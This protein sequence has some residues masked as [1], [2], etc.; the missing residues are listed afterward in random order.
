M[1]KRATLC[2]EQ[3][4]NNARHNIENY[5]WAKKHAA[6]VI[7]AADKY[8]NKYT[9]TELWEL[10]PNQAVFRSYGVNQKLGCL[11]CG[12][13]IDAFGNY[14]YRGSAF[15]APWKVTCPS[16]G[17]TFPS[18]DFGAYYRSALD[19]NGLFDPARGD[20]SLLIN[21]MYPEKDADYGVDDGYG[22]ITPDG[23]KY[24][25]IAYYTHWM[26]WSSHLIDG[27]NLL[28]LAYAYTGEQKYADAGI[29]MLD[30]I[31]D[32][33]PDMSGKGHGHDIGF[34]QS[35]GSS[36]RSKILGCIWETGTA[37]K[38]ANSIDRL[39]GGLYSL[40]EEAKSVIFEK[41]HG[42]KSSCGDI[43]ANLEKGI[44]H[45][46]FDAVR[47]REIDG[48]NGMHQEALCA[49]AVVLDDE[50]LTKKWLDFVFE[51]YG[52]KD[53]L[54][55]G[56]NTSV[57]FVNDIDRD[58]FGG[59][60]SPGYNS[61]WLSCYLGAA[62]ILKNISHSP[63][64]KFEYNLYK[65]PKFK[66]MFYSFTRLIMSVNFTPQIGDT[67]ATG[68]P[69]VIVNKNALLR[70]Y[71]VYRD[72]YLARAVYT[73]NGNSVKGLNLG[74]FDEDAQELRAEIESIIKKDGPLEE[75]DVN[76]TGYGFTSLKFIN[77]DCDN[78]E[79]S[80]A[81]YYGSNVGHGH[82][83]TLNYYLYAYNI[84]I[85]PDLGYPEFCDNADMHRL[86]WVDNTIS[87]NTVIVDNR[88][89]FRNRVGK[90]EEFA[91]F[92]TVKLTSASAPAPYPI[93]EIY[94]RTS[95]LVKTGS[96]AYLVDFF[97]VKGGKKHMLSFHPAESESLTTSG[98]S[99]VP[100][101][102]DNGY[103]VGTM[104]GKDT[105]LGSVNDES[106]LQWLGEVQHDTAQHVPGDVASF[107][108]TITD[109]WKT[110]SKKDIHLKYTLV[111]ELGNLT[112]A[113]GIPP[114]N[115]VGNPK[116]LDYILSEREN[117]SGSLD[118]LFCS[119]VEPYSVK[120][121]ILNVR[122]LRA[123]R[124]GE[125]VLDNSAKAVKVSLSDGRSDVFIISYDR[126]C[127]INI[128]GLFDFKGFFACVRY[129]ADGSVVSVNAVD[130]DEVCGI[131][132]T[133]RFEGRVC[134]FT[135]ELCDKNHIDVVFTGELH[136]D[137]SGLAGKVVYVENDGALNGAY[138]ILSAE[139]ISNNT[140]RLDIG[141]VTLIRSYRN[142]NEGDLG[143]IY[144]ISEGADVHIP[145]TIR[146]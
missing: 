130:A 39:F 100:Q 26:L 34:K 123:F 74:I 117:E 43:L 95:S 107:D 42:K 106:G 109:T 29:V 82:P 48:N 32:I 46:I 93:T 83:D 5:E 139:P 31:A 25:F 11:N 146:V 115:K 8:L 124:N 21:T 3:S 9:L 127:L 27:V 63:S 64:D 22:Y 126:S 84:N 40:G 96:D 16:C 44:L 102:D 58:G 137:I 118:S 87:H 45:E 67:G 2:T 57:T 47:R 70:G 12:H 101:T 72:P 19:E 133:A 52:I 18:N 59:E 68:S 15:D 76:L 111:G 35:D 125:P 104:L 51:P 60:A 97:R 105:E 49:A 23:N 114:R 30:R 20:R 98:V 14:P 145:M 128:D 143:Y 69:G 1:K 62:E 13:M 61:I 66:K 121:N 89:Q 4:I 50:K 135:K 112:L 6:S 73:Y 119:V 56:A 92:D 71:M 85:M 129:A 38:F 77:N 99:L 134:G 88:R 78:P 120:S 55:T 81:L 24:T 132:G 113:A 141:D 94:N 10:I 33:Y 75:D 7:S 17:M 41:S 122:L 136:T 86:Y 79:N 36:G 142:A 138:N 110:A 37:L 54:M 28:S 80:F 65:N 144:N 116:K 91:A 131:K 108:F 90:P 103:F 140:V 53:G